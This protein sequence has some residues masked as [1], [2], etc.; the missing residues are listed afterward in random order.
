M[1]QNPTIKHDVQFS[2]KIMSDFNELGHLVEVKK[3]V[4]KLVHGMLFS[5]FLASL[6]S[7]MYD[8]GYVSL[9]NKPLI[10]NNLL[11]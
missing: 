6:R 7:K 1:L 11:N 2:D 9:F 4:Y 8:D 5:T 3:N 10:K